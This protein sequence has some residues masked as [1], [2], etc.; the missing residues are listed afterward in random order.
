[1]S[2]S[3]AVIGDVECQH[4]EVVLHTFLIHFSLILMI[5]KVENEICQFD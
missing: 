1:M 5:D 4:G 3:T 2:P